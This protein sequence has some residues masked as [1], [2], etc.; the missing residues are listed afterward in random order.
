MILSVLWNCKNGTNEMLSNMRTQICI[1]FKGAAEFNQQSNENK[2][3]RQPVAAVKSKS[4]DRWILTAWENCSRVW[5]NTNCPCMHSDPVLP[6][7]RPGEVVRVRGIVL[8]YEGD[9]IDGAILRTQKGL[10]VL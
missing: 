8:F 2:L 4:A 3:F 7:C 6:D 1:M 10:A 9:D 5:G